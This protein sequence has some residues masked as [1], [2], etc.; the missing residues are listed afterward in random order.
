MSMADRS[1][2]PEIIREAI[3]RDGRTLYRLARDS[4]V[5]SAVL[6]RFMRGERDF[7]LRTAERVC[8]AIGLELRPLR[9]GKPKGR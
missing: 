2:F 6:G 1:S 4:G 8:K 7:N 5:N 9:K 3:R